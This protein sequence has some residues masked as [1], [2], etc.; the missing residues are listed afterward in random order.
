MSNASGLAEAQ[1]GELAA[2]TAATAVPVCPGRVLLASAEGGS[3]V[4]AWLP[5]F[6]AARRRA[7]LVCAQAE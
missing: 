4:A 5:A 6:R 1:I 3:P 7:L 2:K